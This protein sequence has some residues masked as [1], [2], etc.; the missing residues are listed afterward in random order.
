MEGEPA[1]ET[2][3]ECEHV[4]GGVIRRTKW[5]DPPDLAA[6]RIQNPQFAAIKPRRMRHREPAGDDFARLHVDDDAAVEAAVAPA[7]DGI[8]LA[9]RGDVAGH[10]LLHGEPVQVAAIL[11]DDLRHEGR[12]PQ[13]REAVAPRR[14]GEAVIERVDE[15][16]AAVGKLADVMGVELAGDEDFARHVAAVVEIVDLL[17]GLEHVPEFDDLEQGGEQDGVLAG[18]AD[19]HGLAEEA[20]MHHEPAVEVLAEQIELA[21]LIGGHGKGDSPRSEKGREAGRDGVGD[22]LL[23]LGC[24][25]RR[26][27]TRAF[28]FGR[29]RRFHGGG[30]DA[31]VALSHGFPHR[32]RGL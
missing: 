10:P 6:A 7:V 16:R 4:E 3:T 11:L 12:L 19:A 26:R 28:R 17:V 23:R 27:R 24:R 14:G 32:G 2:R 13:R 20:L 9:H 15:D 18:N 8:G 30:W 31:V 21:G 29:I 25:L 5:L 1:H 22:L